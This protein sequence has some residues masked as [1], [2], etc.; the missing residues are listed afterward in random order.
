[1]HRR[2]LRHDEW[3]DEV[4]LV[5][6]PSSIASGVHGDRHQFC[7]TSIWHRLLDGIRQESS[8]RRGI[9]R[10]RAR[11]NCV[12]DRLVSVNGDM[13]NDN[14][15]CSCDHAILNDGVAFDPRWPVHESAATL[16]PT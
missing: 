13:F 11:H 15:F 12:G 9:A 8:G 7:E 1:V 10:G 16:L 4:L 6:L 5:H 3:I 2:H 14:A